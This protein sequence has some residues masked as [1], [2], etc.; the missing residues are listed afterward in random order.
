MSKKFF[1]GGL[2]KGIIKHAESNFLRFLKN[3][4]EI[5]EGLEIDRESELMKLL[6]DTGNHSMTVAF[7]KLVQ[8]IAF[9][10]QRLAELRQYPFLAVNPKN[11]AQQKPTPAAKQY[12][13]FLQQYNN[14]I[15][16][17]IRTLEKNK[18]TENSPLREYLIAMRRK[19]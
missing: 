5:W 12:K 11:P 6:T 1:H 9:L 10:E 4:S 19:E 7:Q 8:E 18:T 3:F 15:K 14:S 17:M 16:I 2:D 13:E